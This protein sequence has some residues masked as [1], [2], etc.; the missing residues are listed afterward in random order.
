MSLCFWEIGSAELKQNKKQIGE[1]FS[2]DGIIMFSRKSKQLRETT[3]IIWSIFF[4]S[5]VSRA[6]FVSKIKK[7]KECALI[8]SPWEF[9]YCICCIIDEVIHPFF[10]VLDHDGKYRRRWHQLYIDIENFFSEK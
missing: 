10:C 8:D 6:F 1:I 5:P 2:L 3:Q 4:S 7:K 9:S